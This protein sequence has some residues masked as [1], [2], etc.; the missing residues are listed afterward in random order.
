MD[1]RGIIPALA[2]VILL[3]AP[4]GAFGQEDGVIIDRDSPASKEYALPFEE[5]RSAT[6]GRRTDRAPGTSSSSGLFGEGI[7]ET[8][9]AS[10]PAPTKRPRSNAPVVTKTPAPAPAADVTADQPQSTPAEPALAIDPALLTAPPASNDGAIVMAGGAV[11]VVFLVLA[12]GLL[13]RLRQ[14]AR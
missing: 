7:D 14:P 9:S 5:A 1:R 13:L 6:S 8:D 4:G 12:L 11:V 2:T 3:G 10:A